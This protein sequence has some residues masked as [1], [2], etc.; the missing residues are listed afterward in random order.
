MPLLA[1]PGIRVGRAGMEKYHDLALRGRAGAVQLEVNARR[2]GDPRTRP[3]GGQCRARTVGLT[4]D[5]GLQQA[6]LGHLGDESASAVVLDCR[7]GEV[8]AMATNPSFDPSV[9]NSG[10]SQA[11]WV[12]WTNGPRAPL[13]NKATPGCTRRARRS[14]WRW[15]WPR[16]NPSAITPNDRINVR[17]ISIS[18]TRGSIAGARAG[19]GCSTCAAA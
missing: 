6:V 17:A 12:E 4:I 16:W 14:R 10:V 7:N 18:A 2:P 3:P 11:Q 19:T 9:F 15:R 5:A 8:M 13:I 1:L